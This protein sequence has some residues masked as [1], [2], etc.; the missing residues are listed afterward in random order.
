MSRRHLQSRKH[1]IILI[2]RSMNAKYPILSTN[3][4]V[5]TKRK[6]L[7]WTLRFALALNHKNNIA[8]LINFH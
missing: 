8:S 6:N 2:D 4:K 5:K 3:K 7:I 1:L